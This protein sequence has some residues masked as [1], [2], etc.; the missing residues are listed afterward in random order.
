MLVIPKNALESDTTY[1]VR[2]YVHT[3]SSTGVAEADIE[4]T[5]ASA[6]LEVYIDNGNRVIGQT[7]PITFSAERS[8][9]PEDS[10]TQAFGFSATADWKWSWS[11][12]D[13][14]S[15]GTTN[16]LYGPGINQD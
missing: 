5:V 7:Q 14:T 1:Y 16:A 11:C 6:P 10:L 15:F 9:D 8:I 4:I 3:F 2:A 13:W 12:E